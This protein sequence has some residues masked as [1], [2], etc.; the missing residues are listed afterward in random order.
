M[1]R[2]RKVAFVLTGAAW[3]SVAV[4]AQEA[5]DPRAQTVNTR[6][7]V[8]H[9]IDLIEQ[10]RLTA[11]AWE[12]EIAKMIGWGA[13]VE[14]S[15]AG[16]LA[17]YL[18]GRYAPRRLPSSDPGA[19]MRLLSTRCTVCHAADLINAQRLDSTGW[20]RELTKMIG[21]GAVLQ[22]EEM[23]LL[24]EHLAVPSR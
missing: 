16:D 1:C 7:L 4:V 23:D 5:A 18:A 14:S 22:E 15:R 17:A 21:W 2:L 11:A 10:Q 6:C 3:T 24:V 9:G 13:A 19:A 20:R 12:R 8:C